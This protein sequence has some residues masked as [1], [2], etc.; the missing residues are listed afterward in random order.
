MTDNLREMERNNTFQK[1][2][3]DWRNRD[4]PKLL[5]ISRDVIATCNMKTKETDF[6][7]RNLEG[8]VL[9]F[10]HFWPEIDQDNK[11]FKEDIDKIKSEMKEILSK[12][13]EMI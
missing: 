7:L 3:H 10:W 2:V 4:A 8:G 6:E 13:R 12:V 5:C 9:S 1:V 11:L